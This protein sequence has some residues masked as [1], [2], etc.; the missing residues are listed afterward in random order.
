[1]ADSDIPGAPPPGPIPQEPPP[2]V[3]APQAAPPAGQGTNVLAV[4]GLVAGILS[5]IAILGMVIPV[6]GAFVAGG[7]VLLATLAIVL[8]IMGRKAAYRGLGGQGTAM[9]GLILGIIGLALSLAIGACQVACI[10]AVK[11]S[12]ARFDSMTP[13]EREELRKTQEDFRRQFDRDVH[14]ATR[15]ESRRAGGKD[16]APP[17][18]AP[19]APAQPEK[20]GE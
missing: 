13:E 16:E 19:A 14:R 20:A 15:D 9:G 7:G 3:G 10:S 1:M 5:V 11:R 2:A 4:L 12:R 6:L 8:S 18:N 17:A